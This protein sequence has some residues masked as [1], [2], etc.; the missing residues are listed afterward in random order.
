MQMK[1]RLTYPLNAIEI[2][3]TWD[4]IFQAQTSQPEYVKPPELDNDGVQ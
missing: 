1:I 3:S 4:V 2:I